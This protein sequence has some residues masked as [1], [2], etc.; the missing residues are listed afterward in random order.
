VLSYLRAGSACT[1]FRGALAG[2]FFR[3]VREG[4]G[5]WRTLFMGLYLMLVLFCVLHPQTPL[6]APLFLK[7]NL[8]IEQSLPYLYIL[9]CRCGAGFLAYVPTTKVRFCTFPL[10]RWRF[11]SSMI[12]TV[13]CFW[14]GLWVADWAWAQGVGLPVTRSNIWVKAPVSS[15]DAGVR[16]GLGP[17]VAGETFFYF[18]LASGS[19]SV[20]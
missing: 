17:W 5:F 19:P 20:W 10:A 16:Q 18:T 3:N 8:D 4:R 2:S 11:T 9:I 13:L 7:T 14:W 1:G 15:G 6:R 12:L